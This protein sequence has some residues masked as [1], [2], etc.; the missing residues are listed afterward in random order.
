MKSFKLLLSQCLAVVL[1][2]GFAQ[3]S[4]A[5][6]EARGEAIQ[7]YNQAIEMAGQSQFDE[8]ISLYREA[9]NVSQDNQLNDIAE[10]ITQRLPRVYLSRAGG[11]YT[12]FQNERTIGNVDTAIEYFQ[13]AQEAA[14]EFGNDQV[15]QQAR[16]AVPQL[17]YV[18]SV[19]NYRQENFDQALQDLNR[20]LELNPNYAV[21]EYQKAIVMKRMNPEN[22]EGWLAQYDRAIELAQQTNNTETL[23]NARDNAAE[24]LVFRAVNLSENREFNR[25][26]ELLNMARNYDES[27]HQ[28]PYRLAE[29]S[30]KRANW[31]EAETYAREALNLHNGGVAD[32]AKIYFELGT[33]LKGQ[34]QFE[35]A[36]SAFEDA[37]YGDFTEPANHELQFELKCEG[38]SA[39]GR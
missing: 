17:V 29:I 8:A 33:A 25:A 13:E 4:I 5:Q 2:L 12:Q 34:G 11:A 3:L 6:D 7:L 20:A 28:I 39:T 22:V 18:R 23:N 35:N 30:N 10:Q 27:A 19:I 16:G 21:A 38:H 26:I 32:K 14:E 9:L 31:S 1:M 15:A 37:R 36:C 24:E